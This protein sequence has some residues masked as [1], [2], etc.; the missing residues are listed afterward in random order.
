[1]SPEENR[2]IV[3]RFITEV[4]E[5]G[6]MSLLDQLC[7]PNYVNRLTGQGVDSLKQLGSLM[8]TV[9]PRLAFYDRE[10]GSRRRPGRGALHH[11]WN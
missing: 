6:N 5:Q 7:A 9:Y 2:T 3:R 4:L 8:R 10:P 1:M 11:Y